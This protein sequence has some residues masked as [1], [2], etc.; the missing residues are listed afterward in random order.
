VSKGQTRSHTATLSTDGGIPTYI[1]GVFAVVSA[2]CVANNYYAQPLLPLIRADMGLSNLQASMVPWLTQVGYALG[3][4]LII[5]LGDLLQ[6]RN[7]ILA[8]LTILLV[9]LLVLVF[10]RNYPLV[11]IASFA[12][13]AVSVSP[14]IL[15]P[16]A[17]QCAV[18]G[19]KAQSN[20][21]V[22]SGL[23]TGV[24]ASRALSGIVGEFLGWRAIYW[25]AAAL[26][27]GSWIAI[28]R[29]LP[30]MPTNFRGGWVGLMRSVF[31]VARDHPVILGYA[32]RAALCFG[33][34]LAMWSTLAY[35]MAEAPFHAGST[36]VGLLALCGVGG[37][38]T[39]NVAGEYI[40]RFG[41]R[42]FSIAGC[43]LMLIAWV[44]FAGFSHSYFGI[45]VG[46]V[47]LDIGM[48]LMQLS[49]QSAALAVDLAA[50]SRINTV[51]MG[52]YFIGGALGTLLASVLWNSLAWTGVIAVGAGFVAIALVVTVASPR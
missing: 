10:A 32:A 47:L 37:A 16:I 12:V 51:F 20:G 25:V 36:V 9:A 6:R 30:P 27:V 3:L 18:P 43:V 13:G 29:V 31:V 33:S 52:T 28:W 7:I 40:Q 35:K 5:P 8:N 15:I 45:I 34:M 14:Q 17:A 41:I 1:L 19:R 21:I 50:T 44:F 46:I 2:V 24:L 39:A 49:N 48:Q 4:F 42:P 22:L 23:V 26:A 11:L 38:L